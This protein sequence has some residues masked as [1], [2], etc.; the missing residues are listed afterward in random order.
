MRL[1]VVEVVAVT[2]VLGG[3]AATGSSPDIQ[4]LPTSGAVDYQL[5]GGYE[6]ADAVTVVARDR[7]DEPLAGVYSICYVNGFQTQPGELGDWPDELL[8]HNQDGEPFID[9]GWPDEVILDTSSEANRTAILAI[10]G[11]WVDGCATD[12]FQAVEFDNLDTY[13]R[14]DGALSVQDNL[15]LAAALVDRA[16]T[17]GLAA[18]QKN[19]LELG[20]R[21]R[22]DAGFD[23]AVV[24]EC[25]EFEECAGYGAIWGSAWVDIEYDDT[26][27]CDDADRPLLTVVRD[28]DLTPGG[29]Y[30]TC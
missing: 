23:F 8:L 27:V 5:G 10:V 4:S 1:W 24:E 20:T 26:S 30:E 14:S 9:P 2:L 17:N 25:H 3:C 11:E 13:S 21:G 28:R 16:H 7:T 18:G 15:A 6:P 22:D 19:S 29:T 12:G